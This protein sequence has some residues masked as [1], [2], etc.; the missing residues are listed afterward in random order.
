MPYIKK[1]EMQQYIENYRSLE[2]NYHKYLHY[3]EEHRKKIIA[4]ELELEAKKVEIQS[5]KDIPYGTA[6]MD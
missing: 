6:E 4:L 5:L 2:A 1:D 3:Y